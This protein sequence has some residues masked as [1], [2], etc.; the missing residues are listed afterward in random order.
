MTLPAKGSLGYGNRLTNAAVG[1]L[2]NALL[3]AVR[4]LPGASASGVYTIASGAVAPAVGAFR[5]DTEGAA[6][7]DDLDRIT[8]GDLPNGA[9]V[10]ISVVDGARAVNLRHAQGGNGQLLL[11]TSGPLLISSRTQW[12]RLILD[13]SNWRELSRAYGNQ[14]QDF[15]DYLGLGDLATTNFGDLLPVSSDD[16][17]VSSGGGGEFEHGLGAIPAR[18]WGTLRC[19]SADAGYDSGDTLMVDSSYLSSSPRMVTL[20]ANETVVG[21][22]ASNAGIPLAAVNVSNGT[23]QTLTLAKWR[24]KLFASAI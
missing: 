14:L 16:F 17:T 11:A 9:V 3:E 1:D 23:A 5:V 15:R 19:V 4:A 7:L 2:L 18:W 20:Y 22:K 8:P 13:G 21:W 24:L 10:E 6:S 12:V